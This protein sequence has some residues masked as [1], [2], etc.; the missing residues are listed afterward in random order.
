MPLGE[1]PV[2]EVGI[3]GSSGLFGLGSRL[4][5]L[6][7]G[8]LGLGRSL[9]TTVGSLLTIKGRFLI[10]VGFLRLFT[11]SVFKYTSHGNGA[12]I[13]YGPQLGLNRLLGLVPLV[14]RSNDL[15]VT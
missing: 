13:G 6:G 11:E 14:H 9:L 5:G 7:S 3:R 10:V 12:M 2:H 8:L 4:L 1:T 15:D